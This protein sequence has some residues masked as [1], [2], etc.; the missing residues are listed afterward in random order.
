MAATERSHVTNPYYVVI[1]KVSK[2]FIETSI[3]EHYYRKIEKG[4][5]WDYHIPRMTFVG[6]KKTHGHLLYNQKLD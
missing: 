1:T 5:N 4:I 2:M 3:P 6:T